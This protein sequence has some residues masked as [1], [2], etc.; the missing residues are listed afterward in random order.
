MNYKNKIFTKDNHSLIPSYPINYYNFPLAKNCQF[1]EIDLYENEYI[2]IPSDWMHWVFTEPFNL[3]MNYFISSIKH[4]NENL[5]FKNLKKKQPFKNKIDN[6]IN[7]SFKDFLRENL[8]YKFSVA[9]SSINHMVPVKKPNLNCIS[10][11]KI[12]S[13][14][15]SLASEYKNYF[16]YI[17]FLRAVN[18][19]G[20]DVEDIYS[21]IDIKKRHLEKILGYQVL[22]GRSSKNIPLDNTKDTRIGKAYL[23]HYNRARRL[24]KDTP[25]AI[26][27]MQLLLF[28]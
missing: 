26:A 3:S 4:N 10:F 28:E 15:E 24:H 12:M 25:K 5:F 13:I 19:S 22:N 16:K 2:Y 14:R 21:D 6:N 7:F 1:I 9:F 27:G 23:D 17:P 8:D 11:F 20:V 18:E